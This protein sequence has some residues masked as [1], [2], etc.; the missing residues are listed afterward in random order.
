M[1]RVMMEVTLIGSSMRTKGYTR[2]IVRMLKAVMMAQQITVKGKAQVLGL[3]E[4]SVGVRVLMDSTG[5]K[6]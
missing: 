1:K 4:D 5:V 6:Q 3:E 2:Q